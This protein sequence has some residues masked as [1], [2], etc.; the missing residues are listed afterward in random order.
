MLLVVAMPEMGLAAPRARLVV[1]PQEIHNEDLS[2]SMF[3][4]NI[5]VERVTDLYSFA[6]RLKFAS[7]GKTLVVGTPIEGGFLDDEICNGSYTEFHYNIDVF[8]GFVDIGGTRCRPPGYEGHVPGVSGDGTLAVLRFQVV[9]TG[10]SAFEI[11]DSGL[12]DSNIPGVPIGHKVINGYYYGPTVDF[13]EMELT[14]GRAVNLRVYGEIGFKTTIT[15]PSPIPLNASVRYDIIGED[16]W[17]TF[18]SGQTYRTTAP[19]SVYLYVN[20][21]T[22]DYTEWTAVGDSPYLDAP[23]D[24]NYVEG[25][26]D[27]AFM[28]FFGFED[29]TLGDRLID[30][31]QL[32]G[33]TNGPLNEGI[34]YD[35]Y[36]QNFAWV[37]SLYGA[38]A[39]AWVTPRWVGADTTSDMEPSLLTEAG[40]NDFGLLLYLYDPDSLGGPGNIVDCARLRVDF[41]S[42]APVDPPIYTILPGENITVET[43]WILDMVDVGRYNCKAT[44]EFS[45]FGDWIPAAK[46]KE[47]HLRI[48]WAG[49]G[50]YFPDTE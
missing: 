15:N 2:I 50:K 26:F 19:P 45:T 20:E 16:I 34:D 23:D 43:T 46:T 36:S 41:A 18:Y 44:V 17:H 7:Y 32:E 37:G 10:D 30:N 25:T 42:V 29:I 4:I 3:T 31:V 22:A 1:N 21:F 35:A 38:G 11:Q 8:H 28:A 40:I 5:D 39:P 48:F 49:P 47:F 13:V 14:T 12:L 27:A 33:Y 6:L 9:G 24:G